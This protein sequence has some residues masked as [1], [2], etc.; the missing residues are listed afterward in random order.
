MRIA[1]AYLQYFE[2]GNKM[3]KQLSMMILSYRNIEGIYE[4]LDS[5]FVQDYDNIEI[6]ISDDATPDFSSEIDK[7]REYI[8]KNGK[9][10]IKNVVINAIEVNG[11]T[12]KNINSAIRACNGEYIKVLAAEDTLSNETVL[13]DYVAFLEETGLE[14][15][16]GKMRGVTP[17]GEYVYHLQSSAD[18]YDELS[19]YTPEQTLNRL[20]GRN[21]LPAPAWCIK[22]SLFETQGLIPED[23]RLIEDYPY[24]LLLAKNGV[25]FGYLDKVTI[26][27]K[28]SGETSS[29]S[30]GEVFMQDMLKVYDIYIFPH[31]KRY[32]LLQ[33]LYNALKRGGLN[34]YI[35]RARWKKLTKWQRFWKA[36]KYFPF[37]VYTSIL[38]ARARRKNKKQA[39]KREV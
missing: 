37:Y 1:C 10:N 24:W 18:D 32:G 16:F 20:Y 8:A 6:V 7:L 36:I 2:R 33:P 21:F 23:T 14:I 25:K 27:Y 30:Y 5:V 11:G 35:T 3:S 39:K 34:F 13:S 31:D 22:K 15:C 9:E 28:M 4:T 19:K 26:D 38:D 12:V 17:S 29:G